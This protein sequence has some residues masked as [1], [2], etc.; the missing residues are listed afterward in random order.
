MSYTI[1]V[2]GHKATETP[3][4]AQEHEAAVAAKA[5]TF[6]ASLDGVNA[7]YMDG[8]TSG[9]TDLMPAPPAPAPGAEEASPGV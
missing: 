3:E 1:V 2:A 8:A 5:K 7:A 4:E 9:H 6:A